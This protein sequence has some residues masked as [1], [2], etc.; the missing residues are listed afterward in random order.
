VG[1]QY[2]WTSI[3]EWAA[4]AIDEL[5][6]DRFH[7]VVH[8][9]GGPV[10][11]ELCALRPQQITSLTILDTMI[12]VDRF[13]RPRWV[14]TL[15]RPRLGEAIL[16]MFPRPLWRRLMLGVGINDASA[17]TDDELDAWLVLLRG[18]DHGRALVQ[19]LL[20]FET[21]PQKRDLYRHTVRN[22]KVPTQIIWGSKD[23]VLRIS[24][25]GERIRALTG[26]PLYPVPAKHFL[27]EDQ[28]DAIADRVAQLARSN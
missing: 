28:H 9:Y 3:G 6:L 8:D 20:H 12:D 26:A 24:L 1:F 5:G 22:L 19:M 18:R 14:D 2:T 17:V 13:K 10:G 16:R 23:P 15:I 27:Q 7:L 21:T 11:F 25:E 4:T